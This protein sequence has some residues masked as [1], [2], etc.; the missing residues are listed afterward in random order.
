M[1]MGRM[2]NCIK[3]IDINKKNNNIDKKIIKSFIK[4]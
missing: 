3:N 2:K 1:I 4:K